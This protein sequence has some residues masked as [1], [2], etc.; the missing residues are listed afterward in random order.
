ML[1]AITTSFSASAQTNLDSLERLLPTLNGKER[2]NVA[3]ELSYQYCFINTDKALQFGSLELKLATEAGDSASIGMAW[4]DLAAAYISRGEFQTSLV[5]NQKALGVRQRLG[6]S[7]KVAA[8][9]G[10]IG[11]A[12]FEIGELDQ[13]LSAFIRAVKIYETN[14][15][16]VYLSMLLN[17]IGSV[18]QRQGN[19]P[20]AIE[21][22]EQAIEVAKNSGN[23]GNMIA[24]KTN[25]GSIYYHHGDF[26]K[27]KNLLLELVELIEATGVRE[28]LATITMNLG[29]TYLAQGDLDSA[30]HYLS[31]AD[32]LFEA[33]KDK[34]SLSMVKVDIGICYAK[35]KAFD[36]SLQFLE[37]G[38]K[39]AEETGSN[40]QLKHVYEGFKD[41]ETERGNYKLAMEY[42]GKSLEYNQLINS[43]EINSKLAE[44]D[45]RYE[46]EKKEKNLA[47]R[48]KALADA[49]VK[50]KN[51]QLVILLLASGL[52]LILGG[53]ALL[54][55]QQRLRRERLQQKSILALQEERLRIS[56]DL[57]DNIG[58]E[59]TLITSSLEMLSFKASNADKT[60]LE[61]IGSYSRNAM[62]QLR[63]T[64]WA[65]RSDTI[66]VESLSLR[67][68]DYAAKLCKPLDIASQVQVSGGAQRALTPTQ[69]IHLYRLCQEAINNAVKHA[70]CK[71]LGIQICVDAVQIAVDV[72]D[73]GVGFDIDQ[74]SQGYG[75]K[76]MKARAEE[77]GGS[78]SI[79]SAPR[80]GT[81]LHLRLPLQR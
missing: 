31:T 22:F 12:F 43:E 15:Q 49:A 42:L 18:H 3:G 58:A 4:N 76:N 61:N 1:W 34:K 77:M 78:L 54:V 52:L 62:G 33:K 28:H 67:L 66:S 47:L 56:R 30:L 37:L 13:A 48:D 29:A 36:S 80:L 71:S 55:R 17:N 65:I 59:L 9:L 53:I 8:S 23:H 24:A 50:S 46:T 35:M 44:M 25:L 57:H 60:E 20:K 10:R 16:P 39:Y 40:V 14:N 81:Q 69:T 74:T 45:V 38:K 27:Y 2:I 5:L 79:D 63:E 21:Y 7:L 41:L 68:M 72:V 51:Q 75:I 73:N 64:I 32:T 6:D 26:T 11:H 70:H 19:E